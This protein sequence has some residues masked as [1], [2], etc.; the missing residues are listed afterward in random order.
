V[1][2]FII[3]ARR[4][5]FEIGARLLAA[6]AF[7]GINEAGRRR[8]AAIAW[9]SDYVRKWIHMA[10][11][12]ADELRNAYPGYVRMSTKEIKAALRTAYNRLERRIL[13][14]KMARGI[15][16]EHLDRRPPVL[17]SGMSRHSLNEL[18]KLVLREAHQSDPHNVET[19]IWGPSK[20]VIHLASGYDLLARL[21]PPNREGQYQMD[22]L[23]LHR[24]LIR[25]G[26]WAEPIVV[27]ATQ[28]RIGPDQLLRMRLR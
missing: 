17:P 12:Q 16:Q 15:F 22:D 9:C 19:R 10:P 11:Q 4:D 24:F 25:Y 21:L 14:G 1:R 2:L 13:A 6:L 28:F 23:E 26:E 20:P 8:A 3:S 18:S 7:P 27:G 5:P